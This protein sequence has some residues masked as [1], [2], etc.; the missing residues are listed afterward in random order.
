MADYNEKDNYDFGNNNPINFNNE[1]DNNSVVGTTLYPYDTYYNYLDE[2]IQMHEDRTD[3]PHGVTKE[4]VGLDKVDN[5]SDLEKPYGHDIKIETKDDGYNLT[6]ATFYLTDFKGNKVGEKKTIH[7]NTTNYVDAEMYRLKVD[8]DKTLLEF[9][10]YI[11][12]LILD[13]LN[14][15]V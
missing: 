11:D 8:L 13:A 9:K 10:E 6:E 14:T 7:F 1:V 2:K 15:E 4:Q 3:N 12:N 5:T